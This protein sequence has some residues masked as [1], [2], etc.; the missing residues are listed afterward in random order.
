[1]TRPR[2]FGP[3]TL[4]TGCTIEMAQTPDW[5]YAH[6]WLDSEVEIRPGDRV[7]VH[8]APIR[9]RFGETI[10]ERRRATVQRAG[11][12]DGLWTRLMAWFELT[13]LY[14]VSFTPGRIV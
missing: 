1:M 4:D 8:G 2:L 14:E 3:V 5:F 6:A 10:C 9:L 13:E 7:T 11:L 12:I